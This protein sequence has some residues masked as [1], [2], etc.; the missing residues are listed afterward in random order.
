MKGTIRPA[1]QGEVAEFV[2]AS[3]RR[4][5]ARRK[6]ISSRNWWRE[7]YA[8]VRGQKAYSLSKRGCPEQSR[9]RL[10]RWACAKDAMAHLMIDDSALRTREKRRDVVG[11]RTKAVAKLRF[12]L[13][14]PF[15]RPHRE[16]PLELQLQCLLAQCLKDRREGS[17]GEL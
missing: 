3:G 14:I 1:R 7:S 17:M 13:D 9:P 16:E 5:V 12:L 4:K 2:G 11:G 8:D 6:G 10:D 15:P